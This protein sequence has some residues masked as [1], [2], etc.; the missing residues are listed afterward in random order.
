ML[1][2]INDQEQ[3]IASSKMLLELLAGLQL[4]QRKGCAVAV[5]DEVMPQLEWSEKEL[6]HKDK[7]LVINATQGG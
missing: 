5:N 2:Y 3:E 7:I 4:D 6:N 1:V